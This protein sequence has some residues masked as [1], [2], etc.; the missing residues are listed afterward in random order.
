MID[1]IT[2]LKSALFLTH[3]RGGCLFLFD[4]QALKNLKT[5]IAEVESMLLNGEQK[6]FEGFVLLSQSTMCL[7]KG[8]STTAEVL[9]SMYRA[10]LNQ[11]EITDALVETIYFGVGPGSFTGLRL[12]SAFVNG[13]QLG[14]RRKLIALKNCSMRNLLSKNVNEVWKQDLPDDLGDDE[15]AI[16]L[17]YLD[18]LFALEQLS[19][20]SAVDVMFPEYGRL[21]G[22]VL[23][24]QQNI[25]DN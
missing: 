25:K 19:F 18:I 17:T 11:Q 20:G 21:P 15:F 1:K 9:R 16:P 5:L 2:V 3:R 24:L 22:P 6:S 4:S 14:R 13:L 10:A 7:A 12:G 23:K 8:V